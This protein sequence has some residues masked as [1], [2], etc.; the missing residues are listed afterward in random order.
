MF[1][2]TV[3][4]S[5]HMINVVVEDISRKVILRDRQILD[6]DK[7]IKNK[8]LAQARKAPRSRVVSKIQLTEKEMEVIREASLK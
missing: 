1:K 4:T 3:S 5:G 8:L 2:I 7:E 6:L